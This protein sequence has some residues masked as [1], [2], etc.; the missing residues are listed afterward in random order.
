MLKVRKTGNCPGLM[1]TCTNIS[2]HHR[3]WNRKLLILNTICWEDN[4]R[5][6]FCYWKG[7][8]D[9]KCTEQNLHFSHVLRTGKI[10]EV[11]TEKSIP[12]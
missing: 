1:D 12:V 3:K 9:Q 5:A 4:K 7:H 6:H 8:R 10:T 11:I 2:K